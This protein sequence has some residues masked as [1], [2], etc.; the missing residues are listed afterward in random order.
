MAQGSGKAW[1]DM[2]REDWRKDTWREL[3]RK[4][5]ENQKE[6]FTDILYNSMTEEEMDVKFDAGFG[7]HEGIPFT[8]WTKKRVY[9]PKEYDGSEW[10]E[11]APRDPCDEKMG[12]V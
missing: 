12:H 10:V 6:S 3:L 7:S 4:E 2:T 1:C 5:L 9:F 11:S 8:V